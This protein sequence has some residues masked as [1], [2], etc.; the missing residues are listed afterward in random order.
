MKK[1]VLIPILV[2]VMI[3]QLAVPVMLVREKYDILENGTEYKFRVSAY[4]VGK[5]IKFSLNDVDYSSQNENSKYGIISVD[6]DGFARISSMSD[7]RPT[8]AYITS[9]EVGTFEFPITYL[10]LDS[11]AYESLFHRVYERDATVYI[12]VKVKDGK[13]V[14]VNMY[15]DELT[16]TQYL[17]MQ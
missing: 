2:I 8:Q 3:L 13:A 16:I 1:K 10:K 9:N 15:V 6:S 5:K 4:A 12:R 11:R 14:L 17:N 7:K